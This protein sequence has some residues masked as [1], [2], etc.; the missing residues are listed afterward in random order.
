MSDVFDQAKAE[1]GE[2]L[3]NLAGALAILVLGLALAWLLG[4]VTARLLAALGVDR[5]AARYGVHEALRRPGRTPRVSHVVG[6]VVR[7]V[8]ALVVVVAAISTLG[9]GGIELALNEL[10]LYVPR[11]LAALVLLAAGVI[12]GRLIGDWVDRLGTQLAVEAP[13]GRLACALV[14][15]VFTLTALAQLGVPTEISIVL[16]GIVLVTVGLTAALAFGLG[17]RDVA[18]ELSSGRYVSSSFE[19]GDRIAVDSVEGEIVAFDPIVVVV[20]S[21]DGRIVRIPNHVLLHSVVTTARGA[22]TPGG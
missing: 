22:E 7:I 21:A 12:A 1:L 6:R 5:L 4:V 19:L 16:G 3:P 11:L 8:F 2:W 18:R 20:R 17:G 9:I 13:L 10:L 15:G 14:I